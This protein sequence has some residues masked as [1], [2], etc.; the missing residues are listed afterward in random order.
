M[1]Q[2]Q[3]IKIREKTDGYAS[4]TMYRHWQYTDAGYQ[5]AYTVVQHMNYEYTMTDIYFTK[6]EADKAF[7]SAV[8]WAFDE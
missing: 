2:K 5:A 1:S 8:H 7:D 4:V 6:D 3:T